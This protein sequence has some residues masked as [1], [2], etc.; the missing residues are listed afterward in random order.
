MQHLPE[1]TVPEI[2]AHVTVETTPHSNASSHTDPSGA[3][4]TLHGHEE[5]L[6]PQQQNNRTAATATVPTQQQQQQHQSMAPRGQFF[7]SQLNVNPA[8]PAA[9]RAPPPTWDL[10]LGRWRLSLDLFGRVFM[11]DVGLEPG[12]IVAE[13]RGFPVKEA[14]FRRHMEKLRNAQQRDLTL[15][16]ME[17]S[18]AALLTQTF[19]ELNTHF[20]NQSRRVHPPLAFNRVKVTFKDE[21]GEG[22]GVARSFYTSIAEALLAN[23]KLPNLEAAQVGVAGTSG[24]GATNAA[25]SSHKYA[26]PFGS[27][28][29]HRATGGVAVSSGSGGSGAAATSSGGGGI[30]ASVSMSAAGV[31]AAQAATAASAASAL[32]AA[33][34]SSSASRRLGKSLWRPSRDLK[35][36]LNYDVRPFRPAQGELTSFTSYRFVRKLID[37][38]DVLC[39]LFAD[40][41]SFS[42]GSS[43]GNHAGNHNDHLTIQ[44]QQLGERLYPKVQALQPIAAQ[45][46]TGMLLELPPAQLLVMLASDETLRQRTEEAIDIITYKQRTDGSVATADNNGNTAAASASASSANG[47]ATASSAKRPNAAA[48]MLE[49]SA[50]LEDNAP[51]FYAPGKR[52]FYTPRQGL[53]TYERIN[54][55]RNVGRLIGLCLLQNELFPLFLQRHVLKYILGRSI[56]FHDLAFFDPVVY[57]SL[58]QLITEAAPISG[59]ILSSLE[60]AFLCVYLMQLM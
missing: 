8:L 4:H 27:M 23:E 43:S 56:R 28:L 38:V 30:G 42:T 58:R 47:G 33:G 34:A 51:L 10:L 11:E 44:L 46:I 18:R 32:S 3:L 29:R 5:P 26:T 40:G 49:E 12:S 1:N 21:P 53:A 14:R 35:K 60:L 41:G 16:K 31:A 6:P 2:S 7:R 24:G 17:R 45:K 59:S 57:E 13:L 39:G 50:S 48:A 20:G 54:A 37:I 25:V 22:S 52:G 36:A 15:A 19:K 55:F 9:L